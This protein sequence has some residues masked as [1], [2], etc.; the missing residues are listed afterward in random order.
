MD[1]LSENN[2][3]MIVVPKGFNFSNYQNDWP[4]TGRFMKYE[5]HA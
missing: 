3:N 5:L 4:G 2:Y 1:S